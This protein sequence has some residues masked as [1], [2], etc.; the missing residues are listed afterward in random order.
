MADIQKSDLVNEHG[1]PRYPRWV[2]DKKG[3]RV[4][5]KTPDEEKEVA[6]QPKKSADWK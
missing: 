1:K 2:T 3:N 6:A 5:V 4:I